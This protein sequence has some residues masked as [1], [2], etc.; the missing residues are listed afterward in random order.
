MNHLSAR[1][2]NEL[3]WQNWRYRQGPSIIGWDK[4]FF[5]LDAIAN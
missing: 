2:F 4:Y 1:A 5:P 3:T